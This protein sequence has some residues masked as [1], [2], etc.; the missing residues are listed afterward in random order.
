MDPFILHE[1]ATQSKLKIVVIGVGSS[2]GN[3]VEYMRKKEIPGIELFAVDMWNQD[4]H[5]ELSKALSD[6]DIVFITLGLGGNTSRLSAPTIAKIAKESGALTIVIV[7]KPFSFE[8]K[9]RLKLAEDGLQELK[10]ESDCIVAIPNDNLLSIIDPKLGIKESFKIVD[11]IVAKVIDGIS[12]IIFSSEDYDINLDIHDLKTIMNN[13][14]IAIMG[15]GESQG[16]NAVYEAMTSA[17]ELAMTDNIHIK[18]ASGI[19][20][21]F[22]LHPEFDFMKLSVAMDIIHNNTNESAD[23]IFG[24]TTDERMPNDFIRVT[25]IAT[26]VEKA[27]MVPAN[28]VF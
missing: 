25:V 11:S 9:K 28:N 3:I 5:K 22:A 23:V 16:K 21:H 6:S 26:G 13:K 15:I 10:N 2:G 27:P 1:T 17:V 14:G 19:L 18:N 20:V 24:T 4:N 12:G 7:T 8:G